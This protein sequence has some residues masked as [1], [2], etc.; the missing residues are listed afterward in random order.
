MPLQPLRDE[1]P[2]RRKLPGLALGLAGAAVLLPSLLLC[3]LIQILSLIL[4]PFSRHAV[5]AVNRW[6]ADAWWG[7]AAAAARTFLGIRVVVTGD[8]LP[9]G[10]NALLVVNHQGMTDI[11]VLLELAAR[12]GRLGDLK[13][14]VKDVLKWVPGIGWGMVFLDCLFITRAWTEDEGRIRRVFRRILRDRVPVWVASFVEG[15]RLRPGKLERARAW[16][17]ERGLHPLAHVLQPR[18]KGF[19]ATLQGLEGHLDAVYDLVIG[20][21]GGVPDLVQWST[22]AVS[23][24]HLHVRRTAVPVLPP[25]GEGRAAWLLERFREKDRLLDGFYRDGCFEGRDPSL[26]S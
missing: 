8:E 26:P 2:F 16:A 24:V 12:T 20:Y 3:N 9:R 21:E 25:D 13:W 10:E 17:A 5:R 19:V 6:L 22:G 23:R 4:V 15:T 14:Y 11:P 18:T 7:A 1:R